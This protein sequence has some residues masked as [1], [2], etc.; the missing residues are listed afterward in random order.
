MRCRVNILPLV[1]ACNNTVV[2]ISF[3][4]TVKETTE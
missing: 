1:F 2:I 4:V 3:R